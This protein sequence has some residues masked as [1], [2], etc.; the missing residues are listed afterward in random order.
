VEAIVDAWFLAT[1]TWEAKREAVAIG[2]ETEMREFEEANPRPRLKD[3]MIHMAFKGRE[4]EE[5]A[6]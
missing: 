3:F 6:A 4:N 5:V 2:Y 1:I